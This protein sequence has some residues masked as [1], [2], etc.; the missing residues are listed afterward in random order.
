MPLSMSCPS[1]RPSSVRGDCEPT[2]GRSKLLRTSLLPLLLLLRPRVCESQSQPGEVLQVSCDFDTLSQGDGMPATPLTATGRGVQAE[3]RQ[4][5]SQPSNRHRHT[6]H[7]GKSFLI[8]PNTS[9]TTRSSLSLTLQDFL[10]GHGH[11]FGE[12]CGQPDA[13]ETP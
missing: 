8:E 10:S 6:V 2:S 7:L 12:G 9:P 13:I 1:S 3:F 4:P 5:T 11:W